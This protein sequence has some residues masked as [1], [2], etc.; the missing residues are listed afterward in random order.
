MHPKE[1][2][3]FTVQHLNAMR[4]DHCNGTVSQ[5]L[6]VEGRP[7]RGGSEEAIEYPGF[8]KISCKLGSVSKRPILV[9]VGRL[10]QKCLFCWWPGLAF[11]KSIVLHAFPQ[12]CVDAV[13]SVTA[14]LDIQ[15][16][17]GLKVV[18]SSR[19][20]FSAGGFL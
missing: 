7:E 10:Q 2:T 17:T 6:C 15:C 20:G 5:M 16:R 18:S 1:L 13:H 11:C 3:T 12:I 14:V 9:W 8:L 19:G 4:F